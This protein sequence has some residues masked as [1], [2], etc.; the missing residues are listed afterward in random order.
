MGKKN[1][2]LSTSFSHKTQV[3]VAFVVCAYGKILLA[4][5]WAHAHMLKHCRAFLGVAV[6]PSELQFGGCSIFSELQVGELNPLLN[7]G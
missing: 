6:F 5:E 7:A 2:Q 3:V 1:Y 4:T